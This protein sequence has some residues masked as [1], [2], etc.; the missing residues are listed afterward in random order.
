MKGNVLW[1]D[2]KKGFGFIVPEDKS[3][4][5][6]VHYS[7]INSSSEKKNLEKGQQVEF[8][9]SQ[10]EKGRTAINVVALSAGEP[11]QE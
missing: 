5:I 7:G 3:K 11:E 8:D 4:D 1:F 10:N 9:L 2:K 6:F